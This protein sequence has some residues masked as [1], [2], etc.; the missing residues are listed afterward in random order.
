VPSQRLGAWQLGNWS[1]RATP[2]LRL[3]KSP[4]TETQLE[5]VMGDYLSAVRTRGGSPRTEQYYAAILW[6]VPA[7]PIENW[8]AQQYNPYETQGPRRTLVYRLY[9]MRRTQV[10]LEDRQATKLRSVARATQRTVSEIIREAIDEKLDRPS[11]AKAFDVAL[12]QVA[13]IWSDRDGLGSTDDYVRRLRRDRRGR[14]A[15]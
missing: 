12:S 1:V 11:E 3:A 8:C 10:Y 15:R 9:T 5:H 6:R 2:R 13:G 7:T 4:N 14:P